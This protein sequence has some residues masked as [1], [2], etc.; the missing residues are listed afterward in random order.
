MAVTQEHVLSFGAGAFI[1]S[2]RCLLRL[3][4]LASSC[5]KSGGQEAPFGFLPPSAWLCY[6]RLFDCQTTDHGPRPLGLVG[7]DALA[8]ATVSFHQLYSNRRARA[9][10]PTNFAGTK[11]FPG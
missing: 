4:S 2:P 11:K 6:S 8:A 9:R 5:G 3:S 10:F 7:T 1:R